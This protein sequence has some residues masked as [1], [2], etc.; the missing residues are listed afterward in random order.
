[1]ATNNESEKLQIGEVILNK[2]I[3]CALFEDNFAE[4]QLKG[5]TA[6]EQTIFHCPASDYSGRKK[7]D[8]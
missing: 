5:Y 4:A 3:R 7:M 2:N 6:L 1:M 8:T